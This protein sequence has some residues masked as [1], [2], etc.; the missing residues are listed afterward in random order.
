VMERSHE[1]KILQLDPLA[2]NRLS[3][4]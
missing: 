2:K 1:D 3:R 4:L